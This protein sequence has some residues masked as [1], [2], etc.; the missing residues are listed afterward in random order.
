MVIDFENC[1]DKTFR[2]R[3]VHGKPDGV[4]SLRKRL[5]AERSQQGELLSD[6]KQVGRGIAIEFSHRFEPCDKN[7]III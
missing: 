4:G 2:R 5:V 6:R 1:G 3:S 7:Q